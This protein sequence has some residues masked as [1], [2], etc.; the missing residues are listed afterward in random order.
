MTGDAG[1]CSRCAWVDLVR[2]ARG[3]IFLRCTRSE[4]EPERFAKYPR[5]PRF[6]CVGFEPAR[7]PT[8][9]VDA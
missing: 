4:A 3:S 8:R 9:E 7:E 1:L 5:I 2:S 6:E